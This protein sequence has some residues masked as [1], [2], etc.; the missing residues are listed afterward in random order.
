MTPDEERLARFG[1]QPTA[2]GQW[3]HVVHVQSAPDIQPD[4]YVDGELVPIP[5][6]AVIGGVAYWYRAIS[7]AQVER[8]Y[9]AETR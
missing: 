7:R 9:K 8:R 6:D 1:Y 2:D 3:H 5:P 4:T